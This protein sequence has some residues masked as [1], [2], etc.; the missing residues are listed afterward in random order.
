[1]CRLPETMMSESGASAWALRQAGVR[2]ANRSMQR[3]APATRRSINAAP[4][5]T[6]GGV[7]G[8]SGGGSVS[9]Y[10]GIWGIVGSGATRWLRTK[11]TR[12]PRLCWLRLAVLQNLD[13]LYGYQ[14]AR[15]H[16]IQHGQE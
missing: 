5:P 2:H 4:H 13:L 11:A 10:V 1:M 8:A 15:H 6:P 9:D 7:K 12:L 14:P 3:K 16:L